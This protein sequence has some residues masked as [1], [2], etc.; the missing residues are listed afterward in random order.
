VK[1]RGHKTFAPRFLF[2]RELKFGTH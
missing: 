2:L 1:H